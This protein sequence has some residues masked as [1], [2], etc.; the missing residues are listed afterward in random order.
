MIDQH[1]LVMLAVLAASFMAFIIGRMSRDIFPF[2]QPET[3]PRKRKTGKSKSPS[4]SRSV[5]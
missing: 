1:T 3:K 4:R 2:N 5:K